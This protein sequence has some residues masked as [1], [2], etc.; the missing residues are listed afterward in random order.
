[1]TV[2]K[3]VGNTVVTVARTGGSDG[4][5]SVLYS[6]SPGTALAGVDYT[7]T[8]GNLT[9][10]DGDASNRIVSIPII[11]NATVNP[12]PRVFT[13]NLSSAAGGTIG[14]PGTVSININNSDA[15]KIL[16]EIIYMLLMSD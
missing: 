2:M 3:K 1:M 10:A 9:W 13:L 8:V 12:P 6:T 7:T 15:G 4:P 16:T 14:S 5:A 11:N